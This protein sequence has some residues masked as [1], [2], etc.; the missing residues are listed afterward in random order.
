M[1][2]YMHLSVASQEYCISIM[3]VNWRNEKDTVWSLI[4]MMKIQ[5]SSKCPAS[6]AS[7][8]TKNFMQETLE[9][10]ISAF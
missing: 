4:E 10:H 6:S 2:I 9:F 7:S 3:L 5:Y 1:H 8:V